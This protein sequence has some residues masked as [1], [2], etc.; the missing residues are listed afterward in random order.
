MQE[1]QIGELM[2]DLQKTIEE[3]NIQ[4]TV[5]SKEVLRLMDQ[6]QKTLHEFQALDLS[7]YGQDIIPLTSA[8]RNNRQPIDHGR[9]RGW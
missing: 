5:L 1:Q 3:V 4:T 9:K 2:I 6:V 8:M 7:L